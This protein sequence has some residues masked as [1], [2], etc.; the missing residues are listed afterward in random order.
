MLHFKHAGRDA[1]STTPRLREV[2]PGMALALAAWRCMRRR[3]WIAQCHAGMREHD[4]ARLR[5]PTR[6]HLAHTMM[7]SS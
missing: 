2:L 3:C 5:R 6:P 1:A 7:S 4:A